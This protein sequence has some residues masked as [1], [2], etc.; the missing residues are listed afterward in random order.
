M[1]LRMMDDLVKCA[2]EAFDAI[3]KNT[4]IRYW[5]EGES[6]QKAIDAFENIVQERGLSGLIDA[7]TGT[8]M[9]QIGF[10]WWLNN[11]KKAKS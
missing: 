6:L 4:G 7:A 1:N 11:A 3:E 9:T 10:S 2:V 5:T 8:G